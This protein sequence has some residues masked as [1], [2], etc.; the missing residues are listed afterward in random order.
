MKKNTKV[1][2]ANWKM[3]PETPEIAHEIF[4]AVKRKMA[5][6][7]RVEVIICPPY[8]YVE[9]FVQKVG[10]GRRFSIGAQDVF[11]E[12]GSQA[13]TGQV[14]APMLKA[15]GAK[16]VIIGH[17][18]R[19][20][21]GE[22]DS[23]VNKKVLS[24]LK[25]GLTPILC[26]GEK[27]RDPQINYLEFLKNQIKSALLGVKRANLANLIIAYEPVWAIS[28]FQ[29]GSV[30]PSDLHEAIIFVRKA[31]ADLYDRESA[32]ALRVVYGGSVNE[33]NAEALLKG[34]EADGLL[35]GKASLNP[36]TFGTLI[37]IADSFK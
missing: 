28:T 14:N 3:A 5:K 20:Q 29:K 1:L 19:R 26:V 27:E 30:A 10:N 16:Y 35:V 32:M 18:E 25:A 12:T 9:N 34:G 24:A 2:I 23:M 13:F 11:W 8:L 7:K 31:L 6:T 4:G 36:E 17:S 15:A 22:T 37:K 21:F 33:E